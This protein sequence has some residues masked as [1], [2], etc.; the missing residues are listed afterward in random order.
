MYNRLLNF[1]PKLAG[2]IHDVEI[3]RSDKNIIISTKSDFSKR[4]LERNRKVLESA[5]ENIL[6]G[7]F[8]LTFNMTERK[9]EKNHLAETIKDL[10]DSEEIR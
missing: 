5:L 8:T 6:N 2:I 1:S 4:Q 7:D 3:K 9:Q 10:F